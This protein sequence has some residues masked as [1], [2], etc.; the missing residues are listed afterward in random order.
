MFVVEQN[1]GMDHLD[2]IIQQK[3]D[4]LIMYTRQSEEDILMLDEYP[5]AVES[6]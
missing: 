6:I 2:T 3:K 5:Y 1:I 4:K